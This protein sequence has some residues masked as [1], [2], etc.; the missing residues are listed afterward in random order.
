ME[1]TRW[2]RLAPL[3]LAIAAGAV[4]LGRLPAGAAGDPPWEPPPCD[5]GEDAGPPGGAAWYRLDPVVDRQ[6]AL[7]SVRLTAGTAGE[8]GRWLALA[9]ESFASGPVG[10]RILAGSDDGTASHL[11][12]VD[13]GRGCTSAVADEAAVIRSAVLAPDGASIL[14]H[15][16]DRRTRA[17]LGVWRRPLGP[18]RAAAGEPVRVLPGV[19]P[20]SAHGRT[21]STEL[22]VAADGR[23]VVSSCGEVACRDRVLD[24]SD[25]RTWSVARVGPALGLDGGRL[26]ARDAC[27]GDPCGIVA[28][29]L[30]TGAR[31]EVVDAASAAALD[32]ATLVYEVSGGRLVTLELATGRRSTPAEAGGIPLGRGSLARAGAETVAGTVALA[33]GGLPTAAGLRLVGTAALAAPNASEVAR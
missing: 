7:A 31:S 24:P 10:G 3:A 6:G 1:S 13:P 22:L 26:V 17:D 9:P 14:E 2:L 15:R 25:G 28:V 21:F 30:A 5:A 33:P 18:G 11:Q 16:V 19:A 32:G 29:D 20:D 12:L 27:A 4:G 23:L 8:R